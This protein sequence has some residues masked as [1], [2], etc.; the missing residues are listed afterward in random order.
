MA[1]SVFVDES[2]LENEDLTVE[3]LTNLQKAQLRDILDHL[4]IK[5]PLAARKDALVQAIAAHLSLEQGEDHEDS[6]VDK[7]LELEKLRLEFEFKE[8]EK[9][10]ELKLKLE[11]LALT[12]AREERELK[13]EL[14]L[15]KMELEAADAQQSRPQPTSASPGFDLAKNIRLVPKFDENDVEC[16]FT[17]FENRAQSLDW[18]TRY[19][20][21]LLQSVFIGKARK[22]CSNL[23]LE[24]LNNYDDVKTV[25]LA[26][27]ELVPEASR[28]YTT[29]LLNSTLRPN[30]LKG[31]DG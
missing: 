13:R 3:D 22:A 2:F 30:K 7:S 29:Y 25:V 15:R 6:S 11:E 21:Q 4:K 5:M 10:R 18:P 31:I 9:E 17:L 8:K 1:T 23:S 28:R 14:E 16:F 27:Y 24:Q 20:A 12:Q 26:A 19:W